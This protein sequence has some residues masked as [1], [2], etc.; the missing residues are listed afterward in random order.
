MACFDHVLGYNFFVIFYYYIIYA[1]IV[2]CSYI[3]DYLCIQI[4]GKGN[5]KRGTD[6]IDGEDSHV[7]VYIKIVHHLALMYM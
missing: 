1:Y 3:V 4:I 7:K 5:R 2:L 6:V